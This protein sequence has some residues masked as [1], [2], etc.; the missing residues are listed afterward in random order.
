MGWGLSFGEPGCKVTN[1]C[2]ITPK[3]PPVDI[4]Y[5]PYSFMHMAWCGKY[6]K[7]IQANVQ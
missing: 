1:T 3:D 6:A 2:T 7:C 5:E 4:K